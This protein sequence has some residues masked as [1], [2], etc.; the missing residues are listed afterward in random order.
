M[1][2]QRKCDH[3]GAII[4]GKGKRFCGQKC[5]REYGR[6]VRRLRQEFPAARPNYPA[7]WD[8]EEGV[9]DAD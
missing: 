4:T 5:T 8:D 7:E 9:I 2:E 3:C 6:K 1:G